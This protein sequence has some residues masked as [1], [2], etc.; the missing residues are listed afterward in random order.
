MDDVRVPR[1]VLLLAGAVR[2][3]AQAK[4]QKATRNRAR[5]Y[6]ADGAL[7][8]DVDPE[9]L[10]CMCAY[11]STVLQYVL[12]CHGA[13]AKFASNSGHAFVV[14]NGY[15]VDITATQFNHYYDDRGPRFKSVEVLDLTNLPAGRLSGMWQIDAIAQD[16]DAVWA[17]HGPGGTEPWPS[18]QFF[19]SK[20]ELNRVFKEV[21]DYVKTVLSG[22]GQWE[23]A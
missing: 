14:L 19:K 13:D 2:E 21:S 15:G 5:N 9:T 12:R 17:L 3:W 8:L 7:L 18:Y 22:Y 1:R 16:S 11:A 10:E 6:D 20:R 23:T 4:A